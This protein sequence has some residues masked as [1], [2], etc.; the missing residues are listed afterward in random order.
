M[1]FTPVVVDSDITLPG[2]GWQAELKSVDDDTMTVTVST[3]DKFQKICF[4]LKMIFIS[5]NI[6]L[7]VRRSNYAM[8]PPEKS[9]TVSNQKDILV[10]QYYHDSVGRVL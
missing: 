5:Y 8:L 7:S 4:L 2:D 3:L 6:S 1:I 9:L 10:F